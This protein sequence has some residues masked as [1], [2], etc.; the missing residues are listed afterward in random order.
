[1]HFLVVI[2]FV[3]RHLTWLT[4]ALNMGTILF[5]ETLW[6]FTRIHFVTVKKTEWHMYHHN[7]FK[8]QMLF[9]LF[10]F[11]DRTNKIN[12][13][14]HWRARAH[15][16]TKS[17]MWLFGSNCICEIFAATLLY[18]ANLKNASC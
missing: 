2:Y 6:W 13:S 1:M 12:I 11:G 3:I 9:P 14:T 18:S 4:S 15:T 16:H 8:T 7:K 17:Y 10:R 5:S